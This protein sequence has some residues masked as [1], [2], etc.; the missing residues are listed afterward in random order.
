MEKYS[1][2]LYTLWTNLIHRS[3][4]DCLGTSGV[5]KKGTFAIKGTSLGCF[6][7][8]FTCG[9]ILIPFFFLRKF[10]D[11]YKMLLDADMSKISRITDCQKPCTYKE[12]KFV[13]TVLKDLSYYDFPEDQVAFCLWALSENT[14]VEEEVLVYSFHTLVAELGG[15]LGLFLGVSFMTIWDGLKSLLMWG[16]KLKKDEKH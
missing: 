14:L 9:Q 11:L 4:V 3:G 5:N 7:H 10:D 16:M 12:Y 15:S 2:K 8:I 6:K 1:D 13:N